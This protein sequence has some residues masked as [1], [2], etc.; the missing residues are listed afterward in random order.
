MTCVSDESIDDRKDD[1]TEN[2]QE[3]EK[4]TENKKIKIGKGLE[5]DLFDFNVA[6]A[7]VDGNNIELKFEWKN[8]TGKNDKMSML[9]HGSIE[10]YQDGVVIDP[11]ENFVAAQAVI[12]TITCLQQLQEIKKLHTK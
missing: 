7:T 3:V 5:F 2:D 9:E 1:S 4:E 11:K 10:V 8:H 6:D 12:I